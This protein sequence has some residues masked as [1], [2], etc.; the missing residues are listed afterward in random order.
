MLYVATTDMLTQGHTIDVVEGSTS[1]EVEF[2]LITDDK[3]GV[4]I[5]VGSDHTDRELEKAD[6]AAS[7]QV[8][9]KVIGREAWRLT[10]VEGHW[11]RIEMRSWVAGAPYQEGLVSEFMSPKD[12]IRFA[13]SR[14]TG[15]VGSVVI[16]G[17]TLP[18]STP[19]FVAGDFRAELKDPVSGRGLSIDYTVHVHSL[20]WKTNA[21]G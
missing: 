15:P 12:I 6:I 18:L 10:D 2:V 21:R 9:P 16:F 13:S 17:G 5:T 19:S 4:F 14:A 11:D 3:D 7:K 20:A 8:C 1:G